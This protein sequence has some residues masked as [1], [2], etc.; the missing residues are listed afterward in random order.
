M[1]CCINFRTS[2]KLSIL[3]KKDI[4]NLIK[5]HLS[6][7]LLFSFFF[8]NS[9]INLLDESFDDG[10]PAGWTHCSSNWGESPQWLSEHGALKEASGPYFGP[11]SNLII[12][13]E[14]DI[15]SISDPT[16]E[17]DLA[18]AVGDTNVLLSIWW[19]V[20]ST[21]GFYYANNRWIIDSGWNSFSSYGTVNSGSKHI[22][23]TDTFLNNSWTPL[24]NSFQTISLDLSE[25]KNQPR[26]KFAFNFEYLNYMATGVCVIDNV[27][28]F[29]NSITNIHQPSELA[30]FFLYPNPASGL[31][32]FTT[33][34]DFKTGTL[35]ITN[36]T[37]KTLL[38]KMIDSKNNNI[39]IST[40]SPGTY[41]V[42][43]TSVNNVISVQKLS[44]Y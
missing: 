40:Y 3:R 37:G 16:L 2:Y 4:L 26:I 43:F 17:F 6:I 44:I 33:N 11:V 34:S 39:N 25:F 1:G 31:V 18:M 21:C 14:I 9:Q 24:N 23:L 29:G 22:I 27:K 15:T 30:S 19:T 38:E 28:I 7:L 13:P 8:V 12:L 42:Y 10:I 32:N 5:K 41:L 36:L 20:D 35:R